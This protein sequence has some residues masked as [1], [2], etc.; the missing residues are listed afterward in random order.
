MLSLLLSVAFLCC[1]EPAH[2]V[3]APPLPPELWGHWVHSFEEDTATSRVYR[4]RSYEFP[5]ARG[6]EGFELRSTGEYVRYD[7]ARRDGNVAMQGSWKRV[8]P[9]KLEVVVK[10]NGQAEREV[11]HIISCEDGLLKLAK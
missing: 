5:L 1:P 6:R 4:P 11:L 8:G 2:A 3:G 10:R 9:A 7:I